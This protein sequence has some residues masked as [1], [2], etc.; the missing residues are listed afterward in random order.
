M[1]FWL[2]Q[3][4]VDFQISYNFRVQSFSSFGSKFWEN[5]IWIPT[6]LSLPLSSLP[7]PVLSRRG[8]AAAGHLANDA[9]PSKLHQGVTPNGPRPATDQVCYRWFAA[10]RIPPLPDAHATRS[11][12][13]DG[14][15]TT[16]PCR[17]LVPAA[18]PSVASRPVPPP[19]PCAPIKGLPCSHAPEYHHHPAISTA[20]RPRHRAPLS[21]PPAP[22]SRH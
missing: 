10:P 15:A 19:L 1:N 16:R 22:K 17:N 7:S 20:T 11:S 12:I 3:N 6:L 18:P 8:A 13:R 14:R 2:K 9:C 21:T 4:I 5:L